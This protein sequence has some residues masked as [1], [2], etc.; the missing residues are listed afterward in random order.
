VS[1]ENP[2]NVVEQQA[3]APAVEEKPTLQLPPPYEDEF[4]DFIIGDWAGKY[5]L[6]GLEF[7]SKSEVRW[8]FN[9][10]FVR[11]LNRSEGAIGVAESSEVWQ[12]AGEPGAYKLWWF[13]A[14]GNAGVAHGK[15]TPTGW[16]FEGDDPAIG[17]FRNIITRNGEDELLM[18]MEQGPDEN[19]NF[20]VVGSGF[21]RRVKN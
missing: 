12:P 11:G 9:H 16:F 15:L 13:D 3:A 2:S 20:N 1:T 18:R 8:A 5:T 17:G 4:L 14:W 21:Y 19:G 7:D 6:D 10:Q